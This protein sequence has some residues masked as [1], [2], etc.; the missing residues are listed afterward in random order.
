MGCGCGNKQVN[1]S[2]IVVPVIEPTEWGPILWRYLHS[3]VERLGNTASTTQSE[4]ECYYIKNIIT[5]LPLIIPCRECQEHAGAYITENPFPVVMN[6]TGESFRGVIRDWLFQFHTAVRVRKG[7]PVI[8]STVAECKQL[9][10]G[11]SI[12]NNEFSIFINAVASAARN[13]W[14][15]LENWRKWYNFSERFRGLVGGLILN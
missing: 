4:M 7:Q 8:V 11:A 14:V 10:Q 3:A 12:T 6:L 2:M 1:S 15:T 9:Y 5:L 13:K